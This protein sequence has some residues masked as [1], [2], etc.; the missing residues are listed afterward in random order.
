MCGPSCSSSTDSAISVATRRSQC[1]AH[2]VN[3][4]CLQRRWLL[5]TTST[6]PEDRGA[7]LPDCHLAE[8]VLGRGGIVPFEG[9]P[10]RTCHSQWI[11]YER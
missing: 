3:V 7:A 4:R 11:D 10:M 9:P 8:A 6:L 2:V 5:F 1:P